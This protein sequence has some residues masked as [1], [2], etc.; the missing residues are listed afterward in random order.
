MGSSALGLRIA[1]PGTTGGR[2]PAVEVERGQEM[3]FGRGL[4]DAPVDIPLDDRGGDPVAG[5]IRA[6]GGFWLITNLSR[7]RTYVVENEEGTGEY[8]C[9]P[10]GRV[11]MPVPFTRS[12]VT[13]PSQ[14]GLVCLSVTASAPGY[15]A[16]SEP[17]GRAA[18]RTRQAESAFSLDETAKYFL[19][20]VALCEPRVLDYA[21]VAIPSTPQIVK[22]L[23]RHPSFTDI[24]EAAV[25]FHIAYIARRKLRVR[26]DRP[27]Q[28]DR[29]RVNWQREAVVSTALRF[30]LVREEHLA[31]LTGRGPRP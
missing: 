20:L 25:N 28:P 13:L 29:A 6:V 17:G 16:A 11:D 27:E 22:R 31:L 19:V 2:T 26:N 14:A 5:R 7:S 4:A 8:L 18:G 10:P 30:H 3:T 15:L 9:V 24:S 1:V 12:R 21:S 23:Q